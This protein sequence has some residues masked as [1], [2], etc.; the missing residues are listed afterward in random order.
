MKFFCTFRLLGLHSKML[1]FT[2]KTFLV[3]LMVN[4]KPKL[5]SV[6]KLNLNGTETES[7]KTEPRPKTEKSVTVGALDANCLPIKKIY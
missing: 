6:Y 3:L 4:R 7:S 5:F 2:S 1:D